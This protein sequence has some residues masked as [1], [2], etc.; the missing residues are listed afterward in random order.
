MLLFFSGVSQGPLQGRP[1]CCVGVCSCWNHFRTVKA[2]DPTMHVPTQ[3]DFPPPLVTGTS[4]TSSSSGQP[5]W[6][7]ETIFVLSHSCVAFGRC[8]MIVCFFCVDQSLGM[9]SIVCCLWLF[10]FCDKP[11]PY[12]ADPL[13]EVASMAPPDT[14]IGS[15]NASTMQP[16]SPCTSDP[17]YQLHHIVSK[18][19]TNYISKYLWTYISKY[20]SKYVSK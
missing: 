10:V 2:P 9:L 8:L 18:Y 17:W 16:A 7:I 15:A 4:S 13:I 11:P 14:W 12:K 6:H 19:K 3:P 1:Y 20:I 5:N